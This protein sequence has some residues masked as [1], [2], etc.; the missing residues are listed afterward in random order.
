[1]P[2]SDSEEPPIGISP[3]FYHKL[4]KTLGRFK[5]YFL[6]DAIATPRLVGCRNLRTV[7]GICNPN[8]LYYQEPTVSVANFNLKQLQ[9]YFYYK[10]KYFV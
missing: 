9:K 4:R 7:V 8:I 3:E 6:A 1:V 5:A 10:D 2:C